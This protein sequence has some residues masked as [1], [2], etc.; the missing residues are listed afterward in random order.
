VAG[1]GNDPRSRYFDI[2]KQAY[3]YDPHS[4]YVRRWLPELQQVP[5][6]GAQEVWRLAPEM[7]DKCGVVLGE[8]YPRPMINLDESYA[9]IRRR[10]YEEENG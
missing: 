10:M 1:V 2:I 4:T 3:E 8:T 7:L 5:N 9:Q 6:G